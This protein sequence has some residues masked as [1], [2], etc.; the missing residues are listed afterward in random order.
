MGDKYRVTSALERR[1]LKRTEEHLRGRYGQRILN[2]CECTGGLTLA[3][4][5]L[6][7]LETN[8][9][10]IHG[11]VSLVL[12]RYRRIKLLGM[13]IMFSWARITELPSRLQTLEKR[14]N[15]SRARG[16]LCAQKISA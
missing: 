11:P 3:N 14:I 4:V 16:Q 13:R 9:A 1:I 6:W 12:V 10:P 5:G 2:G 8:Y 7:S 15:R